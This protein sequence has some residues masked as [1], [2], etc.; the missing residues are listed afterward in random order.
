[1]ITSVVTQNH[2]TDK[3]VAW[4][5]APKPQK[6]YLFFNVVIDA[7]SIRRS[8]P[9]SCNRFLTFCSSTMFAF[10]NNSN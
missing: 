1:M 4:N 2:K 9:Q 7:T 5:K 10:T 6:T 3:K 8:S